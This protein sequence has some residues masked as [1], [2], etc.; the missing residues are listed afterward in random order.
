MTTKLY[1]AMNAQ[2]NMELWSAYLYLSMSL[3]AEKIG[4][5]GI[6]K[7]FYLQAK[8]E[9]EHARR[10]QQFM[11][12]RD[13]PVTL[14]PIEAVPTTWKCVQ[15]MFEQALA[16]EQKVTQSIHHL[17]TLAREEKDYAAEE[18]L[19]WFVR[20]QVEEEATAKGILM[21]LQLADNDPAA[22]IAIDSRLGCRKEG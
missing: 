15:E 9:Q 22:L 6:G 19:W 12:E 3:H 13:A 1:T 16:H 8:E 7:W 14:Q 20:E 17:V 21:D 18:R 10:F 2:I 5:A 4:R 11:I